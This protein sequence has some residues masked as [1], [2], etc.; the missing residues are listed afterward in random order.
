MQGLQRFIPTEQKI[1]Y[2]NALLQVGF[3]TLDIGSFVSP[4]AVPQMRDTG[5]VL[6]RLNLTGTSTKLLVII[7]NER[8]AQQA[9]A[10]PEIRYMGFPL[11]ISETFQQRN[12]N[13]SIERAFDSLAAIQEL[14][15]STQ[16]ELVVYLSMGFGNPYGDPY[17]PD[18]LQGFVE[19][20][21]A[22]EVGT[23]SLAD[24]VGKATPKLVEEAFGSV[25]PKFPHMEFGAHFHA[26]EQMAEVKVKAAW[27]AGCRRFDAALGGWG[28]CPFA[29]D[30]LTGNIP[31]EMLLGFARKA[32]AL[33]QNFD[34]MAFEEAQ[35]ISQTIFT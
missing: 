27:D 5:E 1:A 8:G 32:G 28:G 21:D 7:A 26:T 6:E 19:K 14:C 10:Y 17:A 3:D 9:A 11:S 12:T 20:L 31:T 29:A 2:A 13:K 33:P 18:M 24:T 34:S 25:I 23:V 15:E 22:L 16:K 4:K 30:E 35:A